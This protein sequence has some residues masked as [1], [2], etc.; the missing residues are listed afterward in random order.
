MVDTE[1]KGGDCR[2]LPLCVEVPRSM[3]TTTHSIMERE[4]ADD[5]LKNHVKEIMHEGGGMHRVS[6]GPRDEP[7]C[8]NLLYAME[9]TSREQG[10]YLSNTHLSL[11]NI[12]IMVMT[13]SVKATQV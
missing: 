3:H 12:M 2:S 7:I 8:T 5:N 9:D 4:K 13:I 11:A 6:H 1:S 10:K